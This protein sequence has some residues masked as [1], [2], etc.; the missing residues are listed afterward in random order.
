MLSVTGIILHSGISQFEKRP[1]ISLQLAQGL[2]ISIH[3]YRGVKAM[4]RSFNQIHAR[5]ALLLGA[6][7]LTGLGWCSQSVAQSSAL[8]LLPAKSKEPSQTVDAPDSDVDNN[9]Q[10]TVTELIR[11][12]NDSFVSADFEQAIDYYSQSIELYNRNAYAYYNRGNSYRKLK[13]SEEALADYALAIRLNPQNSYAYYYRGLLLSE[14]EDYEQA[15]AHYSQ[16]LKLTDQNPVFFEKRAELYFQL[17]DREAGESDHEKAI[18]LYKARGKE[19]KAELLKRKI[20]DTS[21]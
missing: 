2:L 16:A 12:G 4:K 11:K 1:Q 14:A 20:G 6:L 17:E 21:R 5:Q 3:G 9:T 18:K 15:L 7:L 8:E 10:A 19:V 13:R